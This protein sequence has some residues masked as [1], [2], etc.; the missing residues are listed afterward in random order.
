LRIDQ[1]IEVLLPEENQEAAWAQLA[2][3]ERQNNVLKR[4]IQR[5][6]MR[7]PDRLV[8]RVNTPPPKEAA[9][10]KPRPAGKNT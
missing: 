1:G 2:T 9:P 6:D 3:L 5:V 8:L 4:D 7:L 10:A